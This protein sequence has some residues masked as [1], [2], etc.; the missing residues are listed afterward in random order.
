M[1]K[2]QYPYR[3]AYSSI[4]EYQSAFER[5]ELDFSF[6]VMGLCPICG[7][8]SCV[9]QI[10]PYRR[11]VIELFPFRMTSISVVRF[12]C[13]K[14]GRTVSYLPFQL[15]PYFHYS[16]RSIVLALM[17]VVELREDAELTLWSVF[18]H[19]DSDC[20]VTS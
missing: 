15:A 12:L 13:R 17:L 1:D 10:T 7:R 19:L 14:T 8:F 18:E 3:N 6:V 9:R 2:I 20:L 11:T 16:V 4:L 5:G